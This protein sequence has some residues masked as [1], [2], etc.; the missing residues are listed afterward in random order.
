MAISSNRGKVE[1]SGKVSDVLADLSCLIY[2]LKKDV[3]I[4]KDL[5]EGSVKTGLNYNGENTNK[6]TI[7]RI[8]ELLGLED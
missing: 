2:A 6:L 4:P 1:I 8:L 3:K 5:I 7:K